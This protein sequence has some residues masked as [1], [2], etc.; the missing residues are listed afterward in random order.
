MTLSTRLA[1]KFTLGILTAFAWTAA[2][3]AA[4]WQITRLSGDVRVHR[5]SATWVSLN[6][7]QNLNPGD[8]IWTGRNGRVMISSEDGYI[9][10]RPRSMVKIPRQ[11][12]PGNMN[13]IFHGFGTVEA[14]V[15]KRQNHHFSVQ[16]NYLAAVVKGTR[17]SVSGDD[18]QSRLDVEE[19]VVQAIDLAT[20]Q[21]TDIL[22]GQFLIVRNTTD[23]G[24]GSGGTKTGKP[25]VTT[26]GTTGNG[27]GN[28][29]IGV[30]NGG[31]NGTGS[32]GQGRGNG[33]GNR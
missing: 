1:A 22:A 14:V 30:G 9:L 2:A 19:G 4:D 18:Q 21:A 11:G 13:V 5:T 3:F 7:N 26:K 24:T 8:A 17:F 25:S 20:G 28:K 29:G 12:L 15:E 27:K 10:I 33:R 6:A 31:G 32:E 16:S 23:T